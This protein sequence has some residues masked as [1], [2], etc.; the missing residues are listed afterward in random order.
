M[1][2]W[3][4]RVVQGYGLSECMN[5]A[6]TMP[7]GLSDAEYGA[8]VLDAEVPPVGHAI[9]GCE[10]AVFDG[11]G[12]LAAD[13]GVGEVGIRGHS[14]MTGYLAR[15]AETA[16]AFRGGWLR[17]G[18]L[19]R[20]VGGPGGTQ[21][22]TLTGRSKHVIKC[23]GVGVSFEEVERAVRAYA[24]VEDACCVARPHRL[25]GEALTVFV[26]AAPNSPPTPAEIRERV[27]TVADPGRLGLQIVE[28]ESLPRFRNGKLDRRSL[29]DLA[30]H[31]T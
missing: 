10:V 25:L 18:D 6:T 21:L 8:L 17:T 19:G 15:D 29:A 31:D 7:V 14:V 22:L 27:A 4:K 12:R 2:R 11:D 20:Q 28:L 26:V 1:D 13:G 24:A 23:G 30:V 16:A 9:H 3:G 5:F